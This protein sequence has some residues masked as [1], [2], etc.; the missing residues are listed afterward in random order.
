MT[1]PF[2]PATLALPRTRPPAARPAAVADRPPRQPCVP[3]GQLFLR[4]PV[5]WAWLAAAAALPGQALAVGLAVWHRRGCENSPTV[6]VSLRRLGQLLGVSEPVARRGLRALEAAG[7]VAAD[8]RPGRAARV[9]L[10]AAP[11][12]DLASGGPSRYP[13]E[14]P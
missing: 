9:T 1:D 11:A 3:P 2:D 6:K 4:G 8:R 12:T 7:L 14:T 10:L 13:G 5:P